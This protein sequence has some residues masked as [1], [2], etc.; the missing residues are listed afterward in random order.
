[1]LKYQIN[2]TFIKSKPLV[3]QDLTIGIKHFMEANLNIST[4]F[5]AIDIDP[6]LIKRA[7]E[8]YK[9]ENIS[10]K[11][12]DIMDVTDRVN[13]IEYHLKRKHLNKFSITFCFSITM[14]IHL[15]HGDEGLK[16]FL[17]YVA[18]ISE[19]LVIEPQPWKCYKTAVKR[20]K[21]QNFSFPYFQEL[22]VKQNIEDEMECLLQECGLSKINESESTRTTW[23]RKIFVF[24]QKYLIAL[25]NKH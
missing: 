18:S 20:M 11:N 1:M 17:K 4:N 10:F 24:K 13:T 23:D 21:Q 14:W 19:I 2:R 25:N 22:K 3:M 5:L 6:V 9:E 7:E 15:N 12:I 16:N 8:Q